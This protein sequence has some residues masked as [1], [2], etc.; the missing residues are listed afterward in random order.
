MT[1]T[2]QRP[3]VAAQVL[4]GA[5]FNSQDGSYQGSTTTVGQGQFTASGSDVE[6]RFVVL[7]AAG[8][9]VLGVGAVATWEDG[10]PESA[11][12]TYEQLACDPLIWWQWLIRLL[13]VLTRPFATRKALTRCPLAGAPS[14]VGS[15]RTR[16][17]RGAGRTVGG[18]GR[19][20]DL[21]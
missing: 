6:A 15:S 20:A 2:S 12:L 10:A 19:G 13:A 18:V 8:W 5:N 9:P 4:I 17:G 1:V 11:A 3:G 14:G 16:D 21:H 7:P